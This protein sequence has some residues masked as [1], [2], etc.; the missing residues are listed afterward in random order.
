MTQTAAIDVSPASK[1]FCNFQDLFRR[2]WNSLR[3]YLDQ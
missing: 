3:T 1:S 2:L